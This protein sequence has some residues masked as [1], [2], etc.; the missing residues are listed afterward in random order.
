MPAR[1]RFA[2]ELGDGAGLQRH[3]DPLLDLRGSRTLHFEYWS[4]FSSSVEQAV[5]VNGPSTA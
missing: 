1:S 5:T 3:E 4:Q 2:G